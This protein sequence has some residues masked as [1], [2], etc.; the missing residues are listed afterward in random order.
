MML[1]KYDRNSGRSSIEKIGGV[2][3]N[4][5]FEAFKKIGLI[6]SAALNSLGGS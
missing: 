1:I 6:P 3:K 4:R 5:G 2:Q